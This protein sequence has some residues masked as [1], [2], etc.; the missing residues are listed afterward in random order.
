M[1]MFGKLA[2]SRDIRCIIRSVCE[3][4]YRIG[5][6][7]STFST[8]VVYLVMY[9]VK[10]IVNMKIGLMKSMHVFNNCSLF[11]HAYGKIN[12]KHADIY[13]S[14]EEFVFN[15]CSLFYVY[16]KSH[17]KLFMFDC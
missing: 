10:F 7:K 5:L 12:T 3:K 13:R 1:L 14:D 4:L 11:S 2:W 9:I 15:N 17:T 16:C 6:M 8:T